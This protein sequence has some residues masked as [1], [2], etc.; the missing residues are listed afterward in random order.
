[1][2]NGE[3]GC[4]EYLSKVS[5][6]IRHSP[7]VIIKLVFGRKFIQTWAK[8]RKKEEAD[9][10]PDECAH[11]SHHKSEDERNQVPAFGDGPFQ[12]AHAAEVPQFF[13][14]GGRGGGAFFFFPGGKLRT[15]ETQNHR[16]G[17]DEIERHFDGPGPV[18]V[19]HEHKKHEANEHLTDQKADIYDLGLFE[20]VGLLSHREL[21][22]V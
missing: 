4:G 1:M 17:G 6:A 20:K 14:E 10:E 5:F 2:A 3:C 7:L 11:I 8:Q 9:S 19:F 16:S 21:G 15:E 13:I 18:H 22:F 12:D